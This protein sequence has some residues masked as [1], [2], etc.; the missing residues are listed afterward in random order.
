MENALTIITNGTIYTDIYK[1]NP[2]PEMAWIFF[3]FIPNTD[4]VWLCDC[5]I[6]IIHT[7][8]LNGMY[9]IIIKNIIFGLGL[10]KMTNLCK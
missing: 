1:S 2:N 4:C 10:D 9:E 5:I 7:F 6:I 3:V 8:T